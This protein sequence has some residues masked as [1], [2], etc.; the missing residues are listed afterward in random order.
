MVNSNKHTCKQTL[1]KISMLSSQAIIQCDVNKQPIKQT[2]VAR[3]SVPMCDF[4]NA[5]DVKYDDVRKYSD[6]RFLICAMPSSATHIHT[7]TTVCRDTLEL[8]L[9]TTCSNTPKYQPIECK[10]SDTVEAELNNTTTKSNDFKYL[11]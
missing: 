3:L 4:E 8:N 10:N 1:I 5:F 9:T 6:S 2:H 11:P 7:F